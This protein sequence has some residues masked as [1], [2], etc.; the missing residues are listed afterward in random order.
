MKKTYLLISMMAIL[1]LFGIN[2]YSQ[3]KE[4]KSPWSI[5]VYADATPYLDT[6]LHEYSFIRKDVEDYYDTYDYVYGTFDSWKVGIRL[7]RL[8][9]NNKLAIYSGIHY[10]NLR[11][12]MEADDYGSSPF[13]L[14]NINP[15][16][17][18]LHFI[19]TTSFSQ[20]SDYIGLQIGVKAY[21]YSARYALW[22]LSSSAD[23]NR[24]IDHKM[25]THFYNDNMSVYSEDIESLFGDPS[26]TFSA[27]NLAGG[28]R[29]G[30]VS[31]A[32][33]TLE[34]GPSF[35]LSNHN[36]SITKATVGFNFQA[37]FYL[38]F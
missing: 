6:D 12:S 3:E 7:E 24:L 16:G 31:K 38:P 28:L 10:S 21:V 2:T 8:I 17:Q 37:C 15:T 36:S 22:Y 20:N 25:T 1:M 35:L 13:M 18:D 19:R 34:M 5:G 11:S 30:D 23:I 4:K 33:F 29:F 32:G 14:V 9:L 26:N 27:I